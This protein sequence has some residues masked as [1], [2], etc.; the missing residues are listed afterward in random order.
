MAIVAEYH[1]EHGTAY[2]DD[3]YIQS[4]TPEQRQKNREAFEEVC[5]QVI[6][7]NERRKREAEEAA[8]AG[9]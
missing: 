9:K 5:W 8:A 1:F 4:I 6:R 7:A 2:I 3:S